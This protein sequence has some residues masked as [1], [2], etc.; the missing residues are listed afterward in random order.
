MIVYDGIEQIN[1]LYFIKFHNELKVTISIP[2]EKLIAN[3]FIKYMS[4]ISISEQPSAKI[5]LD[6]EEEAD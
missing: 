2:I 6:K 3:R 5:N 4:K 1:G